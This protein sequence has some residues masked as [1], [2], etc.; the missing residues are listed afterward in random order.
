MNLAFC[1]RDLLTFNRLFL[2]S[3]LYWQKIG[4]SVLPVPSALITNHLLDSQNAFWC[5]SSPTKAGL[6]GRMFEAAVQTP[7]CLNSPNNLS[8]SERKTGKLKWVF[9]S[10]SCVVYISFD[11]GHRLLTGTAGPPV[12]MGT[13]EL[14][15]PHQVL[16]DKFN[17]F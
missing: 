17:L 12:N 10:N 14:K 4:T 11:R 2:F 8:I 16:A 5:I 3:F 6:E 1:F 13:W 7:F 15:S 9:T